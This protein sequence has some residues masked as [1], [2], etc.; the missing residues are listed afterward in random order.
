MRVGEDLDFNEW[1]DIYKKLIPQAVSILKENGLLALEIGHNQADDVKK[2]IENEGK[3][4]KI[5]IL[6]DY[7]GK[8]RMIFCNKKELK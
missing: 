5:R 3:Y 8:D 7:S 2:I 6:E 4:N 1:A